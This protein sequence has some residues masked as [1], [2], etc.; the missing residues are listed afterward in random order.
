M[1]EIFQ[2]H[3]GGEFSQI[4]MEELF[5]HHEEGTL[6]FVRLNPGLS[7]QAFVL[8]SFWFPTVKVTC[9]N[10]AGRCHQILNPPASHFCT[11]TQ[12]IV[13]IVSSFPL[14]PIYC[15]LLWV[16]AAANSLQSLSSK[17]ERES[18]MWCVRAEQ[19]EAGRKRRSGWGRRKEEGYEQSWEFET[20]SAWCG[21]ALHTQL[22]SS[23]IDFK[24]HHQVAQS[25]DNRTQSL[26]GGGKQAEVESA[27]SVTRE[28]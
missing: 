7:F 24:E 12:C 23:F 10:A 9:F 25:R 1:N 18:S 14:R 11:I 20:G 15:K 13:L 17:R 19:C 8:L 21:S 28:T 4:Q 22:I 2:S 5:I 26:A 3:H 27:G 6:S 16:L